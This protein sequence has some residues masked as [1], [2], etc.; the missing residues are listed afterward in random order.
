M[1]YLT[2]GE[3]IDQLKGY[4]SFEEALKALRE[5]KTITWQPCISEYFLYSYKIIDNEIKCFNKEGR[6]VSNWVMFDDLI[7]G[8]WTIEE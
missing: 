6:E 3:M 2:T 7:H 4:V 8:K 1:E 5:G